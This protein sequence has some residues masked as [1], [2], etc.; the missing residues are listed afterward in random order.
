MLL[1]IPGCLLLRGL[2]PFSPDDSPLDA[3]SDGGLAAA[4]AAPP[5]FII[6]D[7]AAED[8]EFSILVLD[9]LSSSRKLPTITWGCAM[10][11][12]FVKHDL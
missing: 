2:S 12:E 9:F 4:A 11:L 7:G 5:K 10:R 3:P 6:W 8:P 1:N